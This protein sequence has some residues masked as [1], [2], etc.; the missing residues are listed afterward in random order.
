MAVGK[1]TLW[2]VILAVLSVSP[3]QAQSIAKVQK[4]VKALERKLAAANTV[5]NETKSNVVV[6][7]NG[8]ADLGNQIENLTATFAEI[9]SYNPALEAPTLG[10]S[11]WSGKVLTTTP[12]GP[13]EVNLEVTFTPSN[14]GEGSF[15]SSPR[16]FSHPGDAG[17]AGTYRGSYKIVGNL[18]FLFNLENPP[19]A[20]GYLNAVHSVTA[21]QNELTI[22]SG[23]SLP[24]TYL[25]LT[26]QSP[27]PDN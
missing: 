19:G 9:L 18:I 23:S 10:N 3:I 21:K 26:R 11:A 8:V 17:Q 7:Q 27:T 25:I 15:A 5:V 6:V 1:C 4:Q 2:T 24:A 13:S 22:V 14:L 12:T 16:P 20:T